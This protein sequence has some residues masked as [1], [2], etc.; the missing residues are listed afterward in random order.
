MD[1]KTFVWSNDSFYRTD[2][3]RKGLNVKRHARGL[4]AQMH[5]GKQHSTE[6]VKK[7]LQELSPLWAKLRASASPYHLKVMAVKQAAWPR[8]L[9][10]IAT[11]SLSSAT[12]ATLRSQVMK[13]LGAE[14]SGCN[15]M[16]HL[17]CVEVPSLDPKVWTILETFRVVRESASEESLGLLIHEALDPNTQIPA[18]S[19]TRLL[20]DRIHSLG[21]TCTQGVC[22]HDALGEFSLM[23]VLVSKNLG[24]GFTMPGDR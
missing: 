14:G 19:L 13:G 21:W 23:R 22:V 9:H 18:H 8:Q 6:V 11:S 1:Q 15:P 20:V 16:L 17:G 7:R 10:G 4:G 2:Y 12:L 3:R 24:S 5:F